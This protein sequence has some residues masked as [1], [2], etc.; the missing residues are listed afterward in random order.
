[1]KLSKTRRMTIYQRDNNQCLCCGRTQELSIDHI[2]PRC[3]GSTSKNK[4]LQTLC[5]VCNSMKG[6][7]I[8]LYRR[9][10]R[11]NT[12]RYI[13][14]FVKGHGLSRRRTNKI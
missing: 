9:A 14:N 6:T 12:L 4:N 11:E 10:G 3:F 13:S 1:M 2:I 7:R 5:V 8:I